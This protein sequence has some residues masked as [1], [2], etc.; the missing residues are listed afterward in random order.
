[1]SNIEIERKWLID[2]FPSLPVE[3]ELDIEQGYLS[4][5]PSTVRIRKS[6]RSNEAGYRLCIKG[7]GTL[8]R[9][10]VETPLS[11]SQYEALLP[12]LAAP[13]SRKQ[14]RVFRLPGGERLE[15]SLVDGGEPGAFY[16]AEVEFS[17]EE[18]A[19]AFVPPSFLGREVTEEPCWTMAEYCRRKAKA[20]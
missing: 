6:V 12:L 7:N 17:S 5:S 1:M 19:R 4:F 15:C 3:E 18:S 13:P 9:T 11:A 10:E 14:L 16:Y 8:S 2:S 20:L